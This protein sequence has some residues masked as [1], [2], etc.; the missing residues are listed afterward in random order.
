MADREYKDECVHLGAAH[1]DG[2]YPGCRL[3]REW[4]DGCKKDCAD[5]RI[6]RKR[7]R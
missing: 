7:V 2:S 3:H 6:V 1:K 5:K 4:K